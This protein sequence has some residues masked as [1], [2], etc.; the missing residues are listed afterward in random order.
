MILILV[1]FL[2]LEPI[3]GKPVEHTPEE[4]QQTTTW[5]VSGGYHITGS[6]L[7]QLETN[8]FS[9]WSLPCSG[10]VW[11]LTPTLSPS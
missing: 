8:C 10:S 3:H 7:G 5:V 2:T 11:P 4:N 9:A 6:N 1:M